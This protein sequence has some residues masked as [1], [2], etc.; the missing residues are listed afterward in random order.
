MNKIL[1]KA[2]HLP[3][4][5]TDAPHALL[6][7]LRGCNIKC[8]A[9]YNNEKPK[10]KSLEEVKSDFYK[11][12]ELRKISAIAIIGGE[13]LLHPQLFEIISFLK[14]QNLKIELFTNGLLLDETLCYKLA[15]TGVD[16]IFLHVDF[17]QNRPDLQDNSSLDEINSL[18]NAKAKLIKQAG[19]EAAI[20]MTL[21]KSQKDI[22]MENVKCFVNSRYINYFLITLYR[23]IQGL[24][25][26]EGEL[27]N[28]IS[29]I[30][31]ERNVE[32]ELKMEE[33][34][35]IL[36]KEKLNPYCYLTGRINKQTPRWV[37]FVT[38]C[39]FKNE[40]C[41]DKLQLEISNFEKKYLDLYK[42]KHGVYPFF[43]PQN[44]VINS[45]QIFL[46][47]LFG[48]NFISNLTF[49][50]KNYNRVKL[51]KRL[52]IQSPAEILTNNQIEHCECCPDLTVHK[53][54]IV[55]VCICDNFE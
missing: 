46:N 7:I 40:E 47:G 44:C 31:K 1:E 45:V 18:R 38:A 34:I 42:K 25:M 11:I 21:K 24:G 50:L 15:K 30:F 14:E 55:P 12:L 13:P 36:S 28:N 29:G 9:C 22:V 5:M 48:K 41:K 49:L 4:T 10:F 37:S 17:G 16:L 52:L 54:K 27:P 3:W 23:D 26:L 20:S 6:D 53:G 39:G 33:V 8:K 19:M 51:I 32:E 2:W 43:N 35:E